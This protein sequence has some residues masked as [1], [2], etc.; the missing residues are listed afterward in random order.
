VCARLRKGTLKPD[1][2]KSLWAYGHG[3]PPIAVDVSVDFNP[4]EYMSRPD[5]APDD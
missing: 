1:L 2:I 4:R 5:E 3:R